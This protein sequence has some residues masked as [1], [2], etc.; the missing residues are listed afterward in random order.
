VGPVPVRSLEFLLRGFVEMLTAVQVARQ[1][2][3]VA[4]DQVAARVRLQV[5]PRV[6][7]AVKVA[8][9]PVAARVEAHPLDLQGPVLRRPTV[10]TEMLE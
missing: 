5:A 6:A 1:A 8:A 10:T 4:Q 2:Q 9:A 7:Q 3:A